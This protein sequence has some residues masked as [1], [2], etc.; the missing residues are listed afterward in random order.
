MRKLLLKTCVLTTTLLLAGVRPGSADVIVQDLT[1]NYVPANVVGGQTNDTVAFTP[2][3][4][5]LGTLQSVDLM[6]TYGG[7]AN[8]GI[9]NLVA[10]SV[11]VRLANASQDSVSFA[12][13]TPLTTV[14]LQ[15]PTVSATLTPFV[16]QQMFS[17]TSSLIQFLYP[18]MTTQDVLLTDPTLENYFLDPNNAFLNLNI[19]DTTLFDT[20][21]NSTDN[22]INSDFQ[23][24]IQLTYTYAS[25][26][27][28]G[29]STGDTTDV[30]EPTAMSLLA[31]ACAGLI[32][33]RRRRA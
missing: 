13:Q 15:G 6:I 27:D 10:N 16:G 29:T 20:P 5:S 31:T 9:Q 18:F 33:L 7:L 22:Q 24:V 26:T 2:F 23:N 3:D 8:A 4:P 11:D 17:D 14:N 1:E 30:P 19:T 21:W 25:N 28:A 32:I 12:D